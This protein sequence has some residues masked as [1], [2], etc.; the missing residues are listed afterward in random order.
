MYKR[1]GYICINSA[2]KDKKG[3]LHS[4]IL[5]SIPA[6][7]TISAPRGLIQNVATEYGVAHLTGLTL[8]ER[9]YAMISVAHPAFRDELKAYADATFK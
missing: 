8:K 6:G 9:A 5:A 3:Q 2:R 7:S 1:Q 4:N